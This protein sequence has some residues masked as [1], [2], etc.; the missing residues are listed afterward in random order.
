M[1]NVSHSEETNGAFSFGLFRRF[2]WLSPGS[3][4]CFLHS[5][6]KTAARRLF[7]VAFDEHAPHP[8]AYFMTQHPL[9]HFSARDNTRTA[10]ACRMAQQLLISE[11]PARAQFDLACFIEDSDRISKLANRVMFADASCPCRGVASSLGKQPASKPKGREAGGNIREEALC[12]TSLR[13]IFSSRLISWQEP[14][15]PLLHAVEQR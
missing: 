1:P 9:T 11:R 3:S 6:G 13:T 2:F 4:H 12:T 8:I 7:S 15:L 10:S 14:P 5:P